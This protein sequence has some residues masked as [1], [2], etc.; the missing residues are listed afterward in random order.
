M[1]AGTDYLNPCLDLNF[2][3]YLTIRLTLG[4]K[5]ILLLSPFDPQ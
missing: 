5:A 4:C 3:G 2:Y 1:E